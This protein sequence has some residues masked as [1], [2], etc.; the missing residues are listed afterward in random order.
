[1]CSL[2]LLLAQRCELDLSWRGSFGGEFVGWPT[3]PLNQFHCRHLEHG[4]IMLL[5]PE[6]AGLCSYSAHLA[7]SGACLRFVWPK[8]NNSKDCDGV[9]LR[10]S[11]NLRFSEQSEND[12]AERKRSW[13]WKV[14]P[15]IQINNRRLIPSPKTQDNSSFQSV[16]NYAESVAR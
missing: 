6:M 11:Q 1:M 10:I 4:W 13:V 5:P 2:S 8:C 15:L 12:I 7:G 14:A 9:V 16:K 3:F